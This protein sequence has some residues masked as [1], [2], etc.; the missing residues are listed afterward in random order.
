MR[1][2]QLATH[3]TGAA[4]RRAQSGA[5]EVQ[6]LPRRTCASSSVLPQPVGPASSRMW[7][8]RSLMWA[9]MQGRPVGTVSVAWRRKKSAAV[10][11]GAKN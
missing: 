6:P 9:S 4:L 2:A 10:S 1:L 11:S 8:G 5:A 7:P 3:T